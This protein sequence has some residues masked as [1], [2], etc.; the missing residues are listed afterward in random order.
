L[1]RAYEKKGDKKNAK[2]YY[3]K[4]LKIK[5]DYE[6][7]LAALKRMRLGLKEE[8]VIHRTF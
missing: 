8:E 4:A 7:A 1:G 2:A 5:K 6:P 3:K